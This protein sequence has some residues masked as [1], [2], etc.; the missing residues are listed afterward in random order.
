MRVSIPLMQ[1]IVNDAQLDVVIDDSSVMGR[2]SQ[3]RWADL[4]GKVA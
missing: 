3:M 2:P 4:W 1:F